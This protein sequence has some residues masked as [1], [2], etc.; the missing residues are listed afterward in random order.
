MLLE[1]L[2]SYN[3]NLAESH[4]NIRNTGYEIHDRNIFINHILKP[5]GYEQKNILHDVPQRGD[6]GSKS[7]DIRLYGKKEYKSKHSYSQFIIE[8]K[9]YKLLSE[10]NILLTIYN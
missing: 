10:K 4:K 6:K 1:N 5:L 9:N 7:P 2:Q 3:N 8:T